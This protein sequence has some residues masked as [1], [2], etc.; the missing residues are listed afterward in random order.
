MK[1]PVC[2]VSP[3]FVLVLFAMT[4][5]TAISPAQD[6]TPG[7][8]AP[9]EK[10]TYVE[11]NGTW[12][13][14]R[15][16]ETEHRAT[17][18]GEIVIQRLR[19]PAYEGDNSVSWEREVDT[20][21][22]PDGTVESQ[23]ILRNPDGYG[24]LA[25]VQIIREKSTR[26]ADATHVERE[27]LERPGGTPWQAV[28]NERVTE[29]GP[30]NARQSFKEVRRLNLTTHEWEATEQET[31]V[32]NTTTENGTKVSA[33]TSVRQIPDTYG[34]LADFERQQERIVS[35]DG[36][37]AIQSTVYRR[38]MLSPDSGH[39]YLLDRSTTEVTVAPGTTTRHVVRESDLGSYSG[40]PEIVEETTTVEKT[41]PDGSAHTVTKVI[42]RQGSSLRPTYTEIV[43]L[44][45]AGYVRRIYIPA[46]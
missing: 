13:W 45:S 14:T 44:D 11:Q 37:L 33:T 35:N 34:E 16:I 9:L 28:Q 7:A 38:D 15:T 26:S 42:G 31:S 8:N 19:A 20:R 2:C 25:P 29:K 5:L 23:Y 40:Y 6:L 41:A 1:H 10:K 21:K 3:R 4:L 17:S 24:Y 27:T 32:T 39:F 18:D 22:L 43:D 36:K 46:E 12:R 30:D